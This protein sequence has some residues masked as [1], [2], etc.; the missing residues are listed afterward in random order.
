MLLEIGICSIADYSQILY[1]HLRIYLRIYQ[2]IWEIINL[3]I[4]F[5]GGVVTKGFTLQL[6]LTTRSVIIIFYLTCFLFT[7]M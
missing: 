5:S 4:H 3:N 6:N 1:K 2:I 7:Y